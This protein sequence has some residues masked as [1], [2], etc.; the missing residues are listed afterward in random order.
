MSSSIPSLKFEANGLYLFLS[1]RCHKLTFHW[2][3][4]LA[5]TA[6]VGIVYHLLSNGDVWSFETEPGDN[7]VRSRSFSLALKIAI[8]EPA[9]HGLVSEC[10][11]AIPIQRYSSRFREDVTCRVWV[12]EALYELDQSGLIKLVWP[13]SRIETDA[14][15]KASMARD[16]L[17]REILTCH[18]TQA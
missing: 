17:R 12:K 14:A 9:L 16:N 6:D 4:Y 1:E 15:V 18:G 8:I 2:G 13:I 5:K 7:L 10:L 3:L 11:E